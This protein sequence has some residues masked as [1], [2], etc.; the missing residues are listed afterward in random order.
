[1]LSQAVESV[2]AQE[3]VKLEVLVVDDASDDDSLEK[4]L[5]LKRGRPEIRVFETHES[6]THNINLPANIAFKRAK[7]DY[8]VLSPSDI[9][10]VDKRNF[11]EYLRLFQRDPEIYALP[12][13]RD[14]VSGFETTAS[15]AGSCMLKK[16]L[17]QLTGFDER[18]YGWGAEDNDLSYRLRMIGVKQ[19]TAE[20]HVLHLCPNVHRE[21]NPKNDQVHAENCKRRSWAPNKE[22]GEHPK[23]EE[24]V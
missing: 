21:I 17:L 3:D 8:V 19:V 11:Q 16:H 12:H 4:A 9:V 20:A 2:L 1:V 18:M 14:S 23:L 15:L 22:W 6:L 5:R 13:L 24:L 7:Y 10:H